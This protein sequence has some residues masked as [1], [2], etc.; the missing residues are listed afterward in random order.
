MD[1][2]SYDEVLDFLDVYFTARVKDE[3]YLQELKELV[4][5]SRRNRTVTIRP[6]QLL[7]LE[8]RRKFNDY[9]V[10]IEG[11]EK[12]WMNLLSYWQ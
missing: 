1:I 5:G 10:V 8:Y 6:I 7:F 3:F 4:D 9:S 12:I 11:E 2:E